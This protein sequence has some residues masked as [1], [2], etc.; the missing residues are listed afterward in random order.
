[1]EMLRENLKEARERLIKSTE[2][3]SDKQ[4]NI[5]PTKD[6]WSIAQILFHLHQYELFFM[7]MI[8]E[9]FEEE[10]KPVKEKRLTGVTDRSRKVK[11]PIEPATEFLT[12]RELIEFLQTSREKTFEFLNKTNV[13]E[14]SLKSAPHPVFGRLN[15]KQMVEFIGLHELRHIG[16]IEEVKDFLAKNF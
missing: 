10:S 4:L 2:G 16:Q 15:L 7:M 14:L 5:K 6:Q 3:L 1:M 12:R 9:A 8:E 11:T 13:S